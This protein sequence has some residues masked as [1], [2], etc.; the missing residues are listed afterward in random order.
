MIP[1]ESIAY[2]ADLLL[3]LGDGAE[4]LGPAELRERMTTIV[5]HLART[6][7]LQSTAMRRSRTR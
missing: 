6:Y 3:R 7:H 5:D 1:L 2:T 4:V